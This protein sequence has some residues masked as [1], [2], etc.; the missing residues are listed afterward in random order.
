MRVSSPEID[1]YSARFGVRDVK[2]GDETHVP[3][4]EVPQPGPRRAT[5][6]EAKPPRSSPFPDEA[7][8]IELETSTGCSPL[9]TATLRGL[10]ASNTG[11]LTVRVPRS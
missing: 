6:E 5:A 7:Q 8:F 2:P 10:A 1:Q 3:P 9:V 11:I 4:G